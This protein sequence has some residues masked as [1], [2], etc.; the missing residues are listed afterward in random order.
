M[1][2]V[3]TTC[4]RDAIGAKVQVF[5]KSREL[6]AW[7]TAGDGYLARNESVLFFGLGNSDKIDELRITW[8]G[9]QVE[10]IRDVA[11]DQELLIVQGE[12]AHHSF[13]LGVND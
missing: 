2:L 9:G 7:V 4:E 11:V 12:G 8:P 5:A 10:S 3:G 13:R 6:T 1:R